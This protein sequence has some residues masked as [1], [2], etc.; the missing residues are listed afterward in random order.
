V[1]FLVF[2]EF[3]TLMLNDLQDVPLMEAEDADGLGLALIDR[4]K[5]LAML[6]IYKASLF[7]SCTF[8]DLVKRTLSSIHSPVL[9]SDSNVSSVHP[10]HSATFNLR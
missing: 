6:A 2:A 4:R 3:V 1:L 9:M 8:A 10:P 5:F 7:F